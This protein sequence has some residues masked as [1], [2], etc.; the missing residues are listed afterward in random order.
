M[1][2]TALLA[3][4]LFLSGCAH[5]LTANKVV[6]A[7]SST[8]LTDSIV[9]DDGTNVGVGT[10]PVSGVKLTVNGDVRS[11]TKGYVSSGLYGGVRGAAISDTTTDTSYLTSGLGSTTTAA[12]T[13]VVGRV[14]HF[15]SFGRFDH[16]AGTVNFRFKLNGSTV[17]ANGGWTP[18]YGSSGQYKVEAWFV[19]TAV[20]GSGNLDGFIDVTLYDSGTVT[21][22]THYGTFELGSFITIDTTAANTFDASFKWDTANAGNVFQ[23]NMH[24]FN[25][26]N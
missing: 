25:F 16:A 9:Q 14:L 8:F 22:Y 1:K 4:L 10:A 20:G 2:K 21:A 23:S 26:L 13:F 11:L 7:S 18:P 6:K 12:G 3:S 24:V 19:C 5:A 15:I 17:L